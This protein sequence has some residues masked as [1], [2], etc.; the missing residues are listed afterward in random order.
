LLGDMGF[1]AGIDIGEGAHGAGDGAGGDFGAGLDQP[2]AIAGELGV[3]AREFQAHRGGLGVDAV[4][5]ADA[6]RGFVLKGAGLQRGQHPVH[7]GQQ[8]ICAARQLDGEA[9]V[10]HVGAGQALVHE[11]GIL[12]DQ[13][14]QMGEEGDDVVFHLALDL[15][16][17]R[18][19]KRHILGFPDRLRRRR[20]HDAQLGQLVG[21]VRLDLEPDAIFGLRR[22]DV[23]HLGT[24]IARDHRT[25]SI[26]C[27]G[28]GA[29]SAP[30]A[31]QCQAWRMRSRSRFRV[32]PAAAKRPA[33][34]RNTAVPQTSATRKASLRRGWAPGCRR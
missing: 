20:G 2:F 9:G 23:C 21:G 13:L 8:Q 25:A 28:S 6:G 24:G 1:H 33:P 32:R 27:V 17:A 11:A 7:A 22:P 30:V 31:L 16:N 15:I 18:D 26:V 12:A 5:A 14:G 29:R 10:Q 34:I 4:G 19:V 3:K